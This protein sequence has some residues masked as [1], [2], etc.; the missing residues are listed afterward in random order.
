M[1][2]NGVD[3]VSFNACCDV[4]HLEQVGEFVER[5]FK[6]QDQP[7]DRF[8]LDYFSNRS[9]GVRSDCL[10]DGSFDQVAP[11]GPSIV[12]PDLC[13]EIA[14][15]SLCIDIEMTNGMSAP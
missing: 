1:Q 8:L 15:I 14:R 5:D 12:S 10:F 9:S 11:C 4:A 2:P 3:T 6:L 13:E 7:R